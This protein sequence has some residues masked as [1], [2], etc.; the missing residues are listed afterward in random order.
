MRV[1]LVNT[2][3]RSGG[4]AVAAQ[5]LCAALTGAGVAAWLLVQHPEDGPALNVLPTADPWAKRR[6]LLDALPTLFYRNRRTPHWGNAWLGNRATRRAIHD[7][8]PDITHLHWVNHGMLAI[9]DIAHLRGP[10][11]WT[12]HDSWAFTGGCHSPQECTRYQQQCG[13]CPEL[14]SHREHDLSRRVWQRKQAAWR[15]VPFT[16]VTPSRWLATAAASS[17]L[18]AGRRCVVIPNAVDTTIFNPG[19]RAAARRALDVPP[20]ARVFLFGAPGAATDWNKG[21]DLWQAALPLVA[22]QHPE[23][24]AW[25]AGVPDG[26]LS[27]LPL[28][29]REL[30]VL[31]PAQLAQVMAAADAT[32]IPSRMENLPNMAAES[33]A[34]GTPVA[35]FAVGGI[36]EMIEE[37]RTGFLARPHDPADLAQALNKLLAQGESM[38][39]ACAAVARAR[40]APDVVARQH[41]ELYQSLRERA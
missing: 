16:V 11:V 26:T 40:Y 30:G 29:V 12:L 9:R 21:L 3:A 34:C 36:P 31:S 14:R 15:E 17:A 23:A 1:L 28:P 20:N 35:G 38:R 33:L 18:F 8:A 39:T 25:V 2:Y 7:F 6:P 41:L 24:I 27:G 22:R 13:L 19:D 37:G 5:R 10:L 32:V 4:A